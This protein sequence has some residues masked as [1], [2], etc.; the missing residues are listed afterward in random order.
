VDRVEGKAAFISL[1]SSR[2]LAPNSSTSTR[3]LCSPTSQNAHGVCDG[4]GS[5]LYLGSTDLGLPMGRT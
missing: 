1:P 2:V 4:P 3:P 5:M